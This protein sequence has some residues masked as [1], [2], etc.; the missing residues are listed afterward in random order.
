AEDD[1]AVALSR[2]YA[3]VGDLANAEAVLTERLKN[4][5]KNIAAKSALAP[6]YLMTGRPDA[7][8]RVYDDILSLRSGEVAALLGIADIAV[9]EKQWPRAMDYI[10]R[11]LAAVPNDPTPGLMLVNMYG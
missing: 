3:R 9:A 8:K 2:L 6:I 11:A 5:P 1:L 4:D 10:S 7:A